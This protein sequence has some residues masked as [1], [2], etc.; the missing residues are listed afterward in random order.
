M[1][2]KPDVQWHDGTP[3]TADD[4]VFNWEFLQSGDCVG[5]QRHL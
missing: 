2:L 5:H 1:K 4:V 3:F